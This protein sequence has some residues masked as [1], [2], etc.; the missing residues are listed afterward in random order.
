MTDSATEPIRVLIADDQVIAREGLKRVIGLTD[1][2]VVVGE[3]TVAQEVLIKVQETQPDV[4]LLDLK[5]LGDESA[6]VAALQQIKQAA[7]KT[8]VVILTVYEDLIQKARQIGAEAAL[9]KGCTVDELFTI[10]RSVHCSH[11]FPAAPTEAASHPDD[12][13]SDRELDVLA[14]L[15]EGL[16]DRE[17]GERLFL[18]EST[19]KKH[20]SN[21]RDKLGAANRTQA[22]S[23]ALQKGLIQQ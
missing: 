19:V 13:L 10:I 20:V 12:V 14:L 8:K 3:A 1:D 11:K 21:I 16:S 22:V 2:I 15:V 7:P 23:I 5:W 9:E 17:I 18:A 4:V 6:G